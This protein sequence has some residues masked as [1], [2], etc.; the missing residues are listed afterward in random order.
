MIGVLRDMALPAG[1]EQAIFRGNA[2]R[3]LGL[4]SSNG[5]QP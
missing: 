4:K 1:V 3:M 5:G 2:E